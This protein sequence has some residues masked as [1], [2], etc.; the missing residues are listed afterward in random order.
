MG[1]LMRRTIVILTI[2]LLLAIAFPAGAS[3]AEEKFNDTLQLEQN[4]KLYLVNLDPMNNTA[5]LQL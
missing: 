3:G 5:V 1:D 2:A 4:Y